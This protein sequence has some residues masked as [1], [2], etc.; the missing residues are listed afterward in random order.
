MYDG[1]VAAFAAADGRPLW[2][3]QLSAGNN[4][5][6]AVGKDVLIVA[7]GAPYPGIAHPAAELVA[8]GLDR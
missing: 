5:C 6:P 3:A 4:S 7:A 8:Y 2:H 1:R